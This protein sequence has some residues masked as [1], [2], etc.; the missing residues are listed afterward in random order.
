MSGHQ[1]IPPPHNEAVEQMLLGTLM[2]RNGTIDDVADIL[3]PHHF[4]FPAHGRI[5]AAIR[6]LRDEGKHVDNIAVAQACGVDNDVDLSEMG[7]AGYI[8][9]LV[10]S[11]VT[12][13]LPINHAKTIVGLWR[14]RE[15]I[16]LVDRKRAA[17]ADRDPDD[18]RSVEDQI[19]DFGNEL[20]EITEDDPDDPGLEPISV[21]CASLMQRI[22][23]AMEGKRPPLLSTGLPALDEAIGGGLREVLTVL[24]GRPG[25]GKTSLAETIAWH[26][27]SSGG[28][29]AFFSQEMS[30]ETLMLKQISAMTGIPSSR[31]EKGQIDKR[32]EFLRVISAKERAVSLP[33]FVDQM[34]SIT[35]AQVVRRARRIQRRGGL[36]L[37]VVDHLGIMSDDGG[38]ARSNYERM[39]S[40]IK[41][42]QRAQKQLGV[43][44]LVLAQ[45]NREVEKRVDK[46][47]NLSDFRD[48]GQV[49]EYARVIL[50]AYRD[51]YYI[52]RDKP[53]HTDEN[54]DAKMANWDAR[55]AAAKG[56]AEI[57]VAKNELGLAGVTVDLGFD[58]LRTRFHAIGEAIRDFDAKHQNTIDL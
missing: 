51:E 9:E 44:M 14:R 58:A 28:R 32:R 40:V 21:A 42:L 37:V 13:A 10:S 55:R 20:D 29:V 49:E 25:M 35:P 41:G 56:R 12:V 22:S 43:P 18:R 48:T 5:Y 17:L 30:R 46:R 34:A 27:A 8:A 4:F 47:P 15:A 7:G 1:D 23:D 24:G 26:A 19:A 38:Q 54:Y 36:S 3:D 39:S 53:S 33:I 2:V 31:L 16:H 57:Q 11:I 45:L 6:S 50:L 52:Q